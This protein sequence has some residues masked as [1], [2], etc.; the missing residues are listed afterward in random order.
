[1]DASSI[2]PLEDH[3]HKQAE[4]ELIQFE[5]YSNSQSSFLNSSTKKG[6]KFEIGCGPLVI[7]GDDLPLKKNLTDYLDKTGRINLL[8]LF[9]GHKD[10]FP[11]L[12]L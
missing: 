1:M 10:Q 7:R 2:Q 3:N 5:V 6:T 8:D 11:N 4:K 9:Q 12:S